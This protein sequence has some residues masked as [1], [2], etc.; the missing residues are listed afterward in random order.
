[1]SLKDYDPFGQALRRYV[2]VVSRPELSGP[3]G[4]A[5]QEELAAHE[6]AL[7]ATAEAYLAGC[8]AQRVTRVADIPARAPMAPALRL[9]TVNVPSGLAD[10]DRPAGR[11]WICEKHGIDYGPG[12]ACCLCDGP[13]GR[14]ADCTPPLASPPRPRKRSRITAI[15]NTC[16]FLTAMTFCLAVGMAARLFDWP[17]SGILVGAISLVTSLHCAWILRRSPA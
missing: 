6:T 4:D 16:V 10:W 8:V 17:H 12:G 14:A 13:S 11:Q 5:L 2:D 15:R 1:M 3:A 9:A 7:Y